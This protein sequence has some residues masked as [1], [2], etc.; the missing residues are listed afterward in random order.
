VREGEACIGQAEPGEGPALVRVEETPG[1][2]DGRQPDCHYPLEDL[3]DGFGE[4]NEGEGGG[5]VGEGLT[6]FV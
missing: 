5:G 6:G 1:F 3:G 4:N 2:G